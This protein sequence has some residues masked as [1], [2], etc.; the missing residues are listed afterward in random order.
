MRAV[1]RAARCGLQAIPLM[2]GYIQHENH[3]FLKCEKARYCSICALSLI[4]EAS[5]AQT[6]AETLRETTRG[7]REALVGKLTEA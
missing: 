4:S 2:Q 6:K 5:S 1:D 7:E 3:A